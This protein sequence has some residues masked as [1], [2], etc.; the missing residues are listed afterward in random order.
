MIFIRTFCLICLAAAT[1]AA[2][3]TIDADEFGAKLGGWTK[4]GKMAAE[5]A[6]SGASYRTW[7]PR[8]LSAG[9]PRLGVAE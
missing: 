8:V 7:R 1:A 3:V 4:R 5:Y 6:L 9:A 2:Q